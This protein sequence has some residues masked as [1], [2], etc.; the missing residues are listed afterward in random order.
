M[1]Q[2]RSNMPKLFGPKKLKLGDGLKKARKS[3]NPSPKQK[4]LIKKFTRKLKGY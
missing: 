3:A 1:T 2:L 4:S